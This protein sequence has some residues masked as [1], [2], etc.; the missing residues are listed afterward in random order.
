M[1]FAFEDAPVYQRALHLNVQLEELTA[2]IKVKA[3]PAFLDQLRRSSLSIC[4]NI[5]E[6]YG[7][8]HKSEKQNFYR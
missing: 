1:K 3:G 8:W 6:G 7:R 5:A 2:D 4:N